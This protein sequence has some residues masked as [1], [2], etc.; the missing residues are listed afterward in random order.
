MGFVLDTVGKLIAGY[1]QK[2]VPGYEPFTPSD[3][4]HLRG[5]IQQGD[6][7][8]IEGNNRV[9]GIIKYLTQS[10]WS[11]A[12]LYVG[13]IDGA[14]EP[15]GEPHVLIE[16]NIGEG[17]T[18]APLSKYFPYHTRL[19]RPVGLSWEDRNTVC[20][21]AINRIG[22]GYD[23][24]NILDLMR[25]LIPLP[26]PQRWRRRMI[27][28]GSGDP[29][30][31]ICSALIAQAFDAV[32]YPI[33]PKITRAGSKRAKREILHIRDSS[34]YMPRDFDISPYFE[35][36]KPTI[37]EGF[38]YTA[39]HW[40]DK[41]KPLR[42]VAGKP[43]PFPEAAD[44]PRLVPEAIDQGAPLLAEEVSFVEEEVTWIERVAV[45][46]HFLF[47]E[48]VPARQVERRAKPREAD[49]QREMEAA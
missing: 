37:I 8:L 10:T 18:S 31:I 40:A 46:E 30:K 22:F 42:A 3:P 44:A 2:E 9:S 7:W 4:E 49:A 14:S 47:V 33:L 35:I 43:G 17:V 39:L 12:A 20:R 41:Q 6:V 13:P 11:H 45:T 29:T 23:T 26:V 28:F 24:K 48:R 19:C 36:V 16:A 5:I 15:D 34:L 38:D 21:Y 32:R 27:A 1:L 25:Y